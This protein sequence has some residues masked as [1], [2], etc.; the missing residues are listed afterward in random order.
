VNCRYYSAMPRFQMIGF[1]A[2]DTLWHNEMHYI[3]AQSR[4]RDLLGRY[5]TP[6]LID[7]ELHR[8]EMRNLDQYGYGIKGYALSMIETAVHLSDGKISGEDVLAIINLA[9]DLREVNVVL[10]DHAADAIPVLADSYPLMIITKGDPRDQESKIKRS[11]L[12]KHFRQ[13]EILSE[14]GEENY[15]ALLTRHHIRPEHFLMVGNSLRS[16]IWPVLNIGATA[17]Y[18]PH[19]LSWAHEAADPPPSDHPGYHSIQHLGLLP[20]LLELLDRG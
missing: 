7:G 2:D 6:D 1:D 15:R 17:V 13:V 9:R 4:Y 8:T 20:P 19:R 3:K 18:V 10:L 11:G 12:V 14:K 16:D 5:C